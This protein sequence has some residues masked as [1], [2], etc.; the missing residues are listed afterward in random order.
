MCRDRV[1][2]HGGIAHAGKAAG[3]QPVRHHAHQRIVVARAGELH[4]AQ[5]AMVAARHLLAEGFFV[6][7]QQRLD[8]L[9]R[10]CQ[11]CGGA[12]FTGDRVVVHRQQGQC[13]AVVEPLPG[14]V[15]VRDLVRH[16]AH[17]HGAAEIVHAGAHAHGT[18]G[19]REAAVGRHQQA[20]AVGG[21]IGQQHLGHVTGAG[22]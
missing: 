12:V 20:G 17:Q 3:H 19:G 4:F 10:Q 21:A 1:H 16:L 7:G 8:A 18:P 9:V 2:A 5:P 13:L 14:H 11:H 15:V 22:G 6:H